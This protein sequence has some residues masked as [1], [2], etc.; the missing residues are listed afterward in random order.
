M[1]K[2]GLYERFAGYNGGSLRV[3]TI[4]IQ[5]ATVEGWSTQKAEVVRSAICLMS[6]K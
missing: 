2:S 6:R 4:G 5:L 3:V 1:T